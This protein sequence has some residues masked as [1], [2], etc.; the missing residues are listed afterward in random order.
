M[1]R[2]LKNACLLSLML[3]PLL[4]LSQNNEGDFFVIKNISLAGNN[5]T[6][7]STIYRELLVN[8]GD[9]IFP[10]DDSFEKLRQSRENLL[11]T[12]LFNFVDFSWVDEDDNGKVLVV[13]VVE[14]WYLW[15]YPYVA[16][17]DRNISSWLEAK[18]ISRLSLGFDL[19]YSNLFGLKHELGLT[20]IGGYN[21]KLAFLYDIPYLTDNQRLG[22]SVSSGYLRDKEM[23]FMTID[24]KVAYFNGGR[25]FAQKSF[26]TSLKPYFRFGY[27]NRL[28]LELN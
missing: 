7:P 26:F 20:V 24:D 22:L 6:K 13:D 9:T 4:A 19:V 25:D 27:R 23:P 12:S 18:D 15:P 10:D 2:L 3:L 17:A 28:F 5:V 16:Y 8:V 11:N 21:Q 1:L 14:R